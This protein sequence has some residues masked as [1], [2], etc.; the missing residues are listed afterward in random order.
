MFTTDALEEFKEATTYG[1]KRRV[2]GL[3]LKECRDKTK[4]KMIELRDKLLKAGKALAAACMTHDESLLVCYNA[5]EPTSTCRLRRLAIKLFGPRIGWKLS[6][7]GVISL[8]FVLIGWGITLHA[9][10]NELYWKGGYAEILKPQG[11]WIGLG[12]ILIG[13]ILMTS[14]M[15]KCLKKGKRHHANLS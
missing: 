11:E 15:V 5:E 13:I 12:L 6:I 8:F 7:R 3:S 2:E 14:K 1:P 4:E 9:V 10:A